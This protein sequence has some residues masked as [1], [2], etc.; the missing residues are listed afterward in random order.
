MSDRAPWAILLAGGEGRRLATIARDGSGAPVPKQ[1]W[2]LHGS[3]SLLGHTLERLRR[4]VPIGHVLAIVQEAHRRWWQ[5]ELGALDARNVVVQPAGRGTGVALLHAA[6]RV[7]EVDRDPCILVQPSDHEIDDEA[8]W[9]RSI[10]RTVAAARSWP[11]HLI[12]LGVEAPDDP[13]YGWIVPGPLSA[14]GT[15]PVSAFAEKPGLEHASVLRHQGAL[16]STLVLA[17]RVA[18]LLELYWSHAPALLAEYRELLG[19][20]RSSERFAKAFDRLPQ[21]DFSRDILEP[22]A[23][24]LRVLAAETCGWTDLGTP[25]RIEQWRERH[26]PAAELTEHAIAA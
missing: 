19:W 20:S 2:R 1:F 6:H 16:C 10:D 4:S 17:G 24:Q 3:R 26:V 18:A 15:R 9:T 21:V 22:A 23:P 25:E 12:L 5:S 11:D 13:D 8:A 7:L 14:D